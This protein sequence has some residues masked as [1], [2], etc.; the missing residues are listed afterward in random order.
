[1]PL[2]QVE[3]RSSV[4]VVTL[5]DGPRRNAI[6]LEMVGEIETAFDA[7]EADDSMHVVVLTGRPP[8]FCSGADLDE[9]KQALRGDG[10]LLRRVY[11]GFRR[12]ARCP[13]PVLGAINGPAV[14]AGMNLALACDVRLVGTSARLES[15]FPKIGLHP[16]GGHTWMLQ[17]LAGPQ[18]TAA[19]VLFGEAFDG[20]ACVRYGLAYRCV[21]DAD[22]L[23]ETMRMAERAAGFDRSLAIEVKKTCLSMAA[24][25]SH[26]E[27][28]TV[29]QGPQLRSGHRLFGIA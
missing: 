11:D 20:G 19:A 2:I 24:V 18:I 3:R 26:D 21:D 6:S 22:L 5:D 13:L 14:G 17:R 10:T 8:A 16:G 15:R 25:A 27:A 1:M 29:E 23:A 9:L 12:V 28:V 7:I 4:A